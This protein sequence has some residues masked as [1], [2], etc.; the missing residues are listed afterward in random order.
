[1]PGNSN[2]YLAN[3]NDLNPPIVASKVRFVPQSAHK[4]TVCM[5]VEV[6]GCL[7][8]D[9]IVSY[10]APPGDEFAPNFFIED[11]YDGDEQVD[12]QDGPK[13]INGLGVLTDGHFGNNITLLESSRSLGKYL[14]PS[15]VLSFTTTVV[16]SAY[17][18][19]HL[20]LYSRLFAAINAIAPHCTAV[21]NYTWFNES[22]TANGW[23]GWNNK[24]RP[25]T[26]S[27]E[28]S[29]RQ[30]FESVTVTTYCQLDFGVQPFSQ[31]LAYFSGDGLT[32]HPQYVKVVNKEALMS[33]QSQNISLGLSQRIGR[34]VKLE[35]YF[36]NKWLLIS[37]VSFRSQST[38][39][40]MDYNAYDQIEDQALDKRLK[41]EVLADTP[42]ME[43]NL[44][45]S[46]NV[47][48]NSSNG[49]SNLRAKENNQVIRFLA[50]FYKLL[51]HMQQMQREK[52]LFQE[53]CIFW[54]ISSFFLFIY[55]QG[56]L[57]V[58]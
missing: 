19:D 3:I 50:S 27:F 48:S 29:Q 38:S 12:E 42:E 15:L 37:E 35:L 20:T 24:N 32:Y 23:V 46:K 10:M 44:Q 43:E 41:D 25:L 4:R 13:L 51:C 28:F 31:M 56:V 5:R 6:F 36:D 39:K 22:F 53:L 52:C 2:T 47:V 7:Y 9:G 49:K 11:V 57:K 33:H 1:M 58:H 17:S 18:G 55:E 54:F 30:E 34:F 40:D 26:I 16:S 8:E 14:L 21:H 45:T